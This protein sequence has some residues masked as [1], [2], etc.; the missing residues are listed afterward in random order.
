MNRAAVLAHAATVWR[1]PR[2]SKLDP[3]FTGPC[4]D[5]SLSSWRLLER[6]PHPWP[7]DPAKPDKM[8]YGGWWFT[9]DYQRSRAL[10][11]AC[12]F[13]L[14]GDPKHHGVVKEIAAT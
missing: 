11:A 1:E 12:Y 6:K 8:A 7:A 4:L 3:A 5:A 2:F 14:T 13:R 9:A 10:A